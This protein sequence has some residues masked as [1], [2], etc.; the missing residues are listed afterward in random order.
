[1]APSEWNPEVMVYKNPNL[2]IGSYHKILFEPVQ[3]YRGPDAKFDISPE[4]EQ[5]LAGYL[6]SDVEKVLQEKGLPRDPAG[7]RRCPP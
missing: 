1:M 7:T 3:I 6:Q 4:Q 2:D 5:E